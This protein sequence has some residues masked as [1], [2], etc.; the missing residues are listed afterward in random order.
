IEHM[1]LVALGSAVGG[2]LALAA[3]LLHVL[4][5]GLGKSVLFLGSG[6]ILQLT[7]SSR[8]DAVRGLAGRA[9]LVAG[10]FALGLA[11]L[12][13]LPPFSVFA[14]ELGIVRAGFTAGYGWAAVVALL[15]VAV[16]AAAM[17]RSAFGMLFGRPDPAPAPAQ[18]DGA[19]RAAR[20]P[21]SAA[22]P[23][24]AG[25]ALCAALGVTLGP[26]QPLL[27]AAADAAGGTP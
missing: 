22:V 15:L 27:E 8:T 16:A 6:H 14:S 12:L 10:T 19:A 18:A 26:L 21:W 9:P 20:P 2:R 23:L 24:V 5:H 4:G 11:A 13:G 25:L 3:V 17:S 7:G 1:G